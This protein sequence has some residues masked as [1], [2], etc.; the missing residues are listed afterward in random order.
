MNKKVLGQRLEQLFEDIR[1][2]GRDLS[3]NELADEIAS[4]VTKLDL[5][6]LFDA[7]LEDEDDLDE[8]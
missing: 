7:E 1:D 3:D 4:L 6:E 5:E 8:A 2:E